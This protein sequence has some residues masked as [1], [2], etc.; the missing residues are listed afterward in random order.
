[1][2]FYLNPDTDEP[3]TVEEKNTKYSHGHCPL[4]GETT[5]SAGAQVDEGDDPVYFIQCDSCES[6]FV[7][8]G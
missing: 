1:M 2:V 5:W 6:Q 4:C 7:D 3:M 8:E